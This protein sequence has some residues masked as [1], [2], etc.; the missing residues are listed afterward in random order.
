M[1]PSCPWAVAHCPDPASQ[2]HVVL[3][4]AIPGRDQNWKSEVQFL[5]NLYYW[6]TILKSEP[7]KSSHRESGI[8]WVASI[9]IGD[10]VLQE[11]NKGLCILKMTETYMPPSASGLAIQ[12]TESACLDL[13]AALRLTVRWKLAGDIMIGCDS[14]VALCVNSRDKQERREVSFNASPVGIPEEQPINAGSLVFNWPSSGL[15]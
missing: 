3:H 8:S 5:Q 14:Q 9:S 6:C 13:S 10:F 1:V 4:V 15:Y 2:E 11:G 12:P 7:C